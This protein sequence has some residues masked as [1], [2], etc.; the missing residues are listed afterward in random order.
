MNIFER[1]QKIDPRVIYIIFFL[2]L[3]IPVLF[4][5]PL[6]LATTKETKMAYDFVEKMPEGSVL[7]IGADYGPS[8]VPEMGPVSKAVL[9]QAFKKNLKVVIFPMWQDGQALMQNFAEEIGKE[10][11]KEYGKD[12][13]NLGWR[14]EAVSVLRLTTDNILSATAG[15]DWAGKKL[16]DMPIMQN[17]TA[18]NKD[19]VAGIF[20]FMTGNPGAAQYLERVVEPKGVPMAV[21]CTAVSAP[22]EMPF[23]R[24]GQYK[25]LVNGLRGAAEYENLV[26]KPG[27]ANA[28]MGAQSYGHL[29]IMLFI[30]LGN[31]GYLLKRSR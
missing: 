16:A 15:V 4:P 23:V 8:T 30:I 31:I 12:W 14:N 9:R 2:V 10:M 19:Q 5:A 3:A 22:G 29:A 21:A 24:S 17:L 7:W 25:G 26:G 20:E 13:V 18:L 27:K 28:G 6:P 1:M 11:K